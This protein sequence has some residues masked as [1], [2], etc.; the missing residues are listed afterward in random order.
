MA[1]LMDRHSMLIR[2]PRR[3][4][5]R[6]EPQRRAQRVGDLC[7]VFL[8]C[9]LSLDLARAMSR[10]RG[11]THKSLFFFLSFLHFLSPFLFPSPLEDGGGGEGGVR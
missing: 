5:N 3:N 8:G 6:R 4:I 1:T 11:A 10:A 7:S 2:G 9:T